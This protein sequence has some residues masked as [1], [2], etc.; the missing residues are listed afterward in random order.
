M[1]RE[2]WQVTVYGITKELVDLATK[3]QS[4]QILFNASSFSNTSY[5]FSRLSRIEYMSRI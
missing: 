2:A 3:Q 1:N 4:Y 5:R